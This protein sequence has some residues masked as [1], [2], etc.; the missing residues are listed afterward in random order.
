MKFKSI[1]DQTNRLYLD[2]D[3]HYQ[4][5]FD[6]TYCFQKF[7]SNLGKKTENTTKNI[8]FMLT[9]LEKHKL[10]FTLGLLGGEPTLNQKD[11]FLILNTF[12]SIQKKKPLSEIYVSTNLSK[13]LSFFKTHPKYN[14]IYQWVSIHP[15]YHIDDNDFFNKLELLL[16]TSLDQ[17]I[18]SPMLY[19]LDDR[20]MSF[21][22]EVYQ[23]FLQRKDNYNI[24]YSPQI[25]FNDGFIKN[26][27]DTLDLTNPIYNSSI[28][29]FQLDD[30][31]F[32]LNEF[33]S[34]PKSFKGSTCNYNYYNINPDLDC[35]GLCTEVSF[36]IKNN[37]IK[38]FNLKPKEIICKMNQCLDYPLLLSKKEFH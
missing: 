14:N 36:N 37:P 31:T 38:F 7:D 16:E 32:T 20:T 19:N 22:E 21:Y 30:K 13:P 33:I 25:I 3:I 26:N 17:F 8:K 23:W 29:E 10:D 15:E 12:K 28:K 27:V 6:C 5:N 1:Y 2:W 24:I 18:L 4:C 34:N 11:Y 9:L 35:S